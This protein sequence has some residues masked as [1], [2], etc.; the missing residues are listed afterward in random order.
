MASYTRNMTEGKPA[1]LI[2]FFC[3]AANVWKYFPT[4]L[5]PGGYD[6]GWQG[7]RS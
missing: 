6:G 3:A 2:L 5:Y 1:R 4:I 7:V